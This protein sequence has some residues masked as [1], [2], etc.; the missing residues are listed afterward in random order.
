MTKKTKAFIHIDDYG[1]TKSYAV[2]KI[3][4]CINNGSVNS[5][6]IMIDSEFEA[7]EKIKQQGS[8]LI[9]L[10]LN[11][12]SLSEVRNISNHENYQALRFLDYFL[13][14]KI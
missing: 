14:A 6:S 9:K 12:T 7:I 4:N 13:L 2:V 3:M 5:V 1:Y 8:V 10:H 11:L